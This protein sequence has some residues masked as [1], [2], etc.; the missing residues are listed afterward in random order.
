M[1]KPIDE[2]LDNIIEDTVKESGQVIEKIEE[3]TSY[4]I[5]YLS[6][7]AKYGSSPEGFYRWYREQGGKI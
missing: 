5:T 2:Q 7:G 3:I 4:M 1:K 6:T